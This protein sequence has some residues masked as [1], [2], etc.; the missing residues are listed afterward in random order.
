MK[1]EQFSCVRFG[2]G[3]KYMVRFRVSPR[4]I[5]DHHPCRGLTASSTEARRP[6]RLVDSS[7]TSIGTL[8]NAYLDETCR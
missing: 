5:V 3:R 2:G 6:S 4:P 8:E 1:H 7:G